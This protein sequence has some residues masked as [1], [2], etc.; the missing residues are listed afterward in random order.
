ML[1]GSFPTNGFYNLYHATVSGECDVYGCRTP[2][3]WIHHNNGNMYIHTSSAV[4]GNPKY[5]YDTP[6]NTIELNKWIT[7]N[8]SQS[9]VGDDYE[10]KIEMNG[11][12]MHMVNSTQPQEFP[13]VKIYISNP[14]YPAAPG[15][16]RNV[17]IK[18]K[19]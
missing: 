12:V 3:I 19:V 2:G 14:W 10:Y 8:I 6:T 18:G 13:N 1:N 9:K 16:V 5:R 17:Y 15:Y 7:I 11:E 4:N